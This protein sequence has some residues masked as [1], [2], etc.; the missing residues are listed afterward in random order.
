MSGWKAGT[1]A[2]IFTPDEPLWLAGY[3]ARTE[4]AKGKISDLRAKALALEDAAGERFLFLTIDLIAVQLG[5]TA[6]S[7]GEHL[8]RRH[9]LPRD[10]VIMAASH[11]H[12]GPEIRTDKALFFGIP[13]EYAAK[14]DLAASRVRQAMIDVADRALASLRP[15]RLM[16]RQTSATFA[17]NRRARGDVVDHD[18][19]VLEVTGDDGKRLAVVFGYACH[20]TTIPPEDCRYCGDWAGFAQEQIERDNPGCAALFVTGAAADQNP[21]P[22]GSVELSQQYGRELA[23]AVTASLQSPGRQIAPRLRIAYEQTPLP[24]ERIDRATLETKLT[25]TDTPVARKAKFLLDA[26]DRGEQL[27]DHYPA[28]IQVVRFGDELLLIALSGEPVND[29]A[30]RFKRDFATLAPQIWIAGYCNDMFGYVPTRRI[31]LEGGYEGGRAN[32]WSWVPAPFDETV[33]TRIIEA[34]RRLVAKVS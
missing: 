8:Q 9:K 5:P 6:S 7:V 18:V 25:S 33:E 4:P 16:A 13:P 29:Y 24:L 22:R 27:I 26:I 3:A 28:P 10:R 2:T 12:Y 1:A 31:Q 21:H 17:D 23:N 34:V 11:T 20:N 32:L 15:A 14:I 30:H 19:P